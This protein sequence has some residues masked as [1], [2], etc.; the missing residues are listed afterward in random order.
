MENMNIYIYIYFGC[1][2]NNLVCSRNCKKIYFEKILIR[3][4]NIKKLY[5]L[6]HKNYSCL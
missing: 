5:I 6:I 4:F 1:R 2:N 3:D